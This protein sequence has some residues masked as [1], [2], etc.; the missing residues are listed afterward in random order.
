MNELTDAERLFD[1][2]ELYLGAMETRW[3]GKDIG[4][5]PFDVFVYRCPFHSDAQ[6]LVT[7]GV[8]MCDRGL[9]AH[10]DHVP[11]REFVIFAN[12]HCNTKALAALL[13]AIGLESHSKPVASPLG[14]VLAGSGPVLSGGNPHYEH[15]YLTAPIKLPESFL[16]CDTI[17]PPVEIAQIIP[18]SGREKQF[19]ETSGV[20]AFEKRLVEHW[21]ELLKFDQRTELV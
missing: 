6:A 2:L 19:V 12:D 17:S 14:S 7:F 11:R 1:H 18:I 21:R 9:A 5:V 8:S 16:S 3:Y 20:S 13:V 4:K 15:L 10:V